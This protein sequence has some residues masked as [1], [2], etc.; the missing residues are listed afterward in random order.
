MR[1]KVPIFL[2]LVTMFPSIT[3]K[4]H[5]KFTI[6]LHLKSQPPSFPNLKCSWWRLTQA[7]RPSSMLSY[8]CF[9]NNRNIHQAT[10]HFCL[11]SD[12]DY[13]SSFGHAIMLKPVLSPWIPHTAVNMWYIQAVAYMLT[14]LFC[15]LYL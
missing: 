11:L 5:D 10:L 14:I 13:W 6:W 1:R 3:I 7:E 8:I 15:F 12:I 4:T 2:S 9:A